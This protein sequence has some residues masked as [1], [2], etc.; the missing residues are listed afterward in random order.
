M[1]KVINRSVYDTETA[2][3]IGYSDNGLFPGDLD[4]YCETLY[5]RPRGTYFLHV[6]GGA[7][8]VCAQP[9]G[10]GWVGGE[11]IRPMGYDDAEKWAE[12]S[13]DGDGYMREFGDPEDD[14]T[15]AATL[16]IGALAKAKLE[17]EAARA[18]KTQSAVVE[19]LI[20]AM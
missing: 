16:K 5:R 3:A 14:A 2:T 19:E 10:N 20:E 8:S 6:E 1:K 18:G 7:R 13:L 12:G 17:R 11:L 9:D 4:Y 15:V